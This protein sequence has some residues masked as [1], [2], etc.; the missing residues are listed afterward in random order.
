MMALNSIENPQLRLLEIE[1]CPKIPNRVCVELLKN[2]NL[3][4]KNNLYVPQNFMEIQLR[5]Y[6]PLIRW[7]L[8]GMLNN[9]Y[10]TGY[11]VDKGVMLVPGN[12]ED[13]LSVKAFDFTFWRY[14]PENTDLADV[15]VHI[16][17]ADGGPGAFGLTYTRQWRGN[18][19][20]RLLCCTG[21]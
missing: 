2:Y 21:L 15:K 1:K 11:R 20:F 3:T 18:T 14:V 8:V 4:Q 13:P 17:M 6:E 16:I 19:G 10:M 5:K 12:Y 7:T 9:R